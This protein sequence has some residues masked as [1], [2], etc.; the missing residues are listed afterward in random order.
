MIPVLQ[1]RW[2]IKNGYLQ[3][4]GL[5]SKPYTFKNTIPISK[6]TE[7]I[8]RSFDG[9]RKIYDFKINSQ[10]K[11]LIHKKVIVDIFEVK[12]RIESFDKA[13]FC[14]KCCAN[15]YMIPGLQLNKYGI[16]PICE[17]MTSLSSLKDVLP[18]RNI[19]EKD[20]NGKYDIAIFYT[21]GKDSSYL[22]YYLSIVLN[23]RVLALTWEIPFMS[24]N[25]KKSMD[26]AVLLLK[27]TDFIKKSLTPKQQSV[28]YKKAYELQNNTCI[29]PF[30]AYMLFID[31]LRKYKVRYLVL[32]NEPA[33]PINLL[34]NNIAPKSY[35]NPAIQ[36]LFRLVYNL[37]RIFRLRKPLKHG[38]IE[39]L[40]LL[41]TLAY[42][43][44][45]TFGSNKTRNPII[46]NIHKSLS[47]ADDLMQPFINTVRQC[48]LD[49]NIPA[50]VHVDFNDI[51]EGIYKWSDV[52]KVLKEKIG[53]QESSSKNKGLHT[54]CNI[55]SCKEYSQFKAFY[56][57]KSEI[58][59]FSAIELCVAVN[60]GNISREDAIREIKEHSGFSN[61]PPYETKQM[62][63]SFK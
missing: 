4:Y 28:I 59:P 9:I 3:Y 29:C 33:Q 56:D 1:N 18:I 19:I 35:F 62:M 15:D 23:L 42:G 31:D 27:N 52:K 54:S 2:I 38:Q 51:S 7:K 57:M 36:N 12:R 41:E 50:L 53:W 45:E 37:T 49:N 30:A 5:R 63:E 34:F 14:K 16:C 48:S 25:A 61:I 55:E 11:K 44:P 17:N 43:K 13:T 10:I 39:F 32:G 26:N 22:L 21:G 6:K 24:E 47:E 46:S 20:P 8:I 40:M 60:M 58:I